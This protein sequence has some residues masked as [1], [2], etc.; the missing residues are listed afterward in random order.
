MANK[1]ISMTKIRQI[2]RLH[3]QGYSKLKIAMQ[4]GI[5]RNTLKK[6]L[7]AFAASG[8]TLEQV[9]VLSDKDL[10]DLFVKPAE[11]PLNEKL[12]TLVHLFP[13]IDKELKKRGVTRQMLWEKYR[14]EH[15]DGLG[16]SQFKQY[17]AQWKMRVNPTMHMEHKVGDKMYIDF[18]GD[19]LHY[20]DRESGRPQPV[21]VFLGI[22]GASQLLYVEGVMTQQRRISSLFVRIT[23]STW[24]AFRRLLCRIT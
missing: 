3:T 20:I 9:E 12:R 10:E 8:M 14:K 24:V 4:T 7:A 22:L 15:Q 23:S 5:A 19:K 18:A 1:T 17:Y 6:Y 13:T 16:L 21:E 2:L 11:K